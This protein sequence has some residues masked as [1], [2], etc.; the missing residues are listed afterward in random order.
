M[1]GDHTATPIERR[2]VPLTRPNEATEILGKQ[3]ST[4]RLL[5]Q[6]FSSKVWVRD[7]VF[8]VEGPKEEADL[9]AQL[10]QELRKIPREGYLDSV[11]VRSAI[12]LAQEGRCHEIKEV[13]NSG[14]VVSNKGR[15]IRPRTPNQKM[16][17]DAI[18]THDIVFCIGPAGTGKTYLAVAAA[19]HCLK[20]ETVGRLILVRPAVEAGEKLGFLPGALEDKIAPYLRPLYDALHDLLGGGKLRELTESGVIEI[21]P[22]AYMRGRS[23]ND[24]FV[25]LDE[26]QN[27]TAEQM[28]MFLTRLG[29]GSKA[30]VTAD[31]TQ[32]DLPK[33]IVS[34]VLHASKILEGIDGIQF[35]RLTGRDVVRHRLV[36][37]IIE[38]Y[39]REDGRGHED[40]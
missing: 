12:S 28:K 17:L 5:Q 2:E 33:S 4:L 30:V 7:Q 38:A 23:L 19:V 39:G 20:E 24:A 22:L 40:A 34:G 13:F 6:A 9:V 29:F 14:V 11:E 25:I 32:T 16:Y 21:A 10:V 1:K 37:K 26:G 8:Y 31:I 35:V 27:S 15:E 36:Q 18:R 3:D